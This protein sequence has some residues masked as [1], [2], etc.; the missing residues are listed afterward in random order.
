M[1]N[2]QGKQFLSI[3]LPFKAQY[4]VCAVRVLCIWD[5]GSW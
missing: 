1:A 2:R 3:L 4:E 5:N